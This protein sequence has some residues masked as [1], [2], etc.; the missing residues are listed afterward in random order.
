VI[1]IGIVL[2]TTRPNRNGE[3]VAKW[4][5]DMASRHSDAEFELIDLRNRTEDDQFRGPS[6]VRSRTTPKEIP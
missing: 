2:G 5:L 6:S 3:Q 1:R 4:V